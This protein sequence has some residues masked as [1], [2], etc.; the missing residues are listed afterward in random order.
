[1]CDVSLQTDVS[2]PTCWTGSPQEMESRL[3]DLQCRYDELVANNKATVSRLQAEVHTLQERVRQQED[4]LALLRSCRSST[5]GSVSELLKQLRAE[6]EALLQRQLDDIRSE[7]LHVCSSRALNS[8]TVSQPVSCRQSELGDGDQLSVTVGNEAV[9]ETDE[10]C[11]TA[12]TCP[13]TAQSDRSYDDA[14][15]Q[16]RQLSP[17]FDLSCTSTDRLLAK[18]TKLF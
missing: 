12:A 3:A 7:C 14:V 5:V 16:K 9:S 13:L 4:E 8:Y 2:S 11:Q 15:S 17:S 6:H 18:S 1:M 10:C